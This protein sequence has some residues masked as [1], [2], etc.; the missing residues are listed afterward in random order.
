MQTKID[1]P[2]RSNDTTNP[3]SFAITSIRDQERKKDDSKLGI[4]KKRIKKI[5]PVPL[6]E[7]I[8]DTRRIS[9][10]QLCKVGNDV[11]RRRPLNPSLYR[12]DHG[13]SHL[14]QTELCVIL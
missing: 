2:V 11:I 12:A 5:Y 6:D 10:I 8:L 9:R 3:T 4:F 7:P 1:R 13:H 14:S